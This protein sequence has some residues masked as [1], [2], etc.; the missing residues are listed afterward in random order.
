MDCNL[1]GK[2]YAKEMEKYCRVCVKG[3]AMI[4]SAVFDRW[5]VAHGPQTSL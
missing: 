2:K 1:N 3:F 5:T 4:H